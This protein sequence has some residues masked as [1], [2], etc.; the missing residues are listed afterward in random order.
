MDPR[1]PDAS[2]VL[3]PRISNGNMADS[4]AIEYPLIQFLSSW[5]A[6]GG[7][8]EA[9]AQFF[10]GWLNQIGRERLAVIRPVLR[11]AGAPISESRATREDLVG[12]GSWIMPWFEIL[13]RPMV[14][15]RFL[16]ELRSSRLSFAMVVPARSEHGGALLYSLAYDLAFLVADAARASRPGL[17][18][19]GVFDPARRALIVTLVPDSQPFDLPTE[20]RNFLVQSVAW[21][22]GVKGRQLRSWYGDFLGRCYDWAVGGVRPPDVYEVFPDVGRSRGVDPR[23][24]LRRPTRS[25]PPPPA[26]L[27]AALAAFRKAGWFVKSR[28]SDEDLAR[29]A[30]QAWRDFEGEEI[31]LTAEEMNWRLLV[32][33]DDRTWSEDVDAGVRPGDGIHEE[34]LVAVWR[35]I[36]DRLGGLDDP[37]EDWSS[38][39]G[40]VLL[41]FSPRGRTRRLLLPS[42]GPYLSP[43]LFTG[44]NALLPDDDGPRLWFTS[45]QAPI[46][47]VTRATATERMSLQELTGLKLDPDPPAWWTELAPVPGQY[48]T[49]PKLTRSAPRRRR[50]RTASV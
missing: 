29:A 27:T 3:V 20:A 37:E 26:A 50:S 9:D 1:S 35:I 15:Q 47:I 16:M 43:A 44:L 49:Q 12:L 38:R 34:T 46:G 42:P 28:L 10:A 19:Q 2:S 45:N 8:S 7:R 33:D 24:T 4:D 11:A 17:Q 21:P 5:W 6:P 36:G 22:R 14:Q 23:Y 13:A 25:G 40:D 48:A 31:P 39:P 30:R 41:S 32:L 18:W